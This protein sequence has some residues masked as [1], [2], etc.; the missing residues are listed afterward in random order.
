[1]TL[2]KKIEILY[3]LIEDGKWSTRSIGGGARVSQ[4]IT[5]KTELKIGSSNVCEVKL[6]LPF[7]AP[8]QGVLTYEKGFL[9][10]GGS[11]Y[12]QDRSKQG[13][14]YLGSSRGGE[15]EELLEKATLIHDKKVKVRSGAHLFIMYEK[16]KTGFAVI[17]SIS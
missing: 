3:A 13:T 6:K 2:A 7:I 14:F 12:Y 1:M 9:G 5:E 10:I 4:P 8:V 16:K 17:P 11:L 15:P